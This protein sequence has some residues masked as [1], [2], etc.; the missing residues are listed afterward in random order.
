MAASKGD[1][2]PTDPRNGSP[3]GPLSQPGYYP[4]YRNLDQQKFWDAKTREVVL[5]R[6]HNIPQIRFFTNEEAHLMK[7]ICEHIIP[8]SDR[9]ADHRIPIVPQIDKRLF[10]GHSDGYRFEDMPSDYEAYRLGLSAIQQIAQHLHGCSFIDA[11]ARDRD[12]IMK[13][14]HDGKPSAGAEIWKRVPVHKFWMMLVQDCV[15]VYYAHPWAWDEIGFGGPAYPRAYMRLE[16][17][18]P[19]P[20]EVDERRYQWKAPACAVSD[21]EEP[22]AGTSEHIATPGRGGTH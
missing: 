19:E 12:E 18:Q 6:V 1:R 16:N 5:A 20:W 2:R 9:D 8:Q 7:V 21:V 14:L 15:E 17:G 10:E 4:G 22:V 13:S 11:G 3:I